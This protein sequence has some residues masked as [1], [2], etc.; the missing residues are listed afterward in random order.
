MGGYKQCVCA[1]TCMCVCTHMGVR[2]CTRV[3]VNSFVCGCVRARVWMP[4][5]GVF[6]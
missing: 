5:C 1:P 3:P 6:G 2:V 4:V